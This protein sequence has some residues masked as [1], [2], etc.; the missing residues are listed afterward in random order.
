MRIGKSDRR[1]IVER[2]THTTNNYG[3]RVESWATLTTVWAELMRNGIGMREKITGD[4]D[5]PSQQVRF[6]IRSSAVSRGIKADDR[7]SYDSNYYNI[8]GIA[9]IGRRDQLVLLCLITGT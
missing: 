9:E 1:I 4:Q 7:V 8:Q 3:E 6:K 2:A 5:M